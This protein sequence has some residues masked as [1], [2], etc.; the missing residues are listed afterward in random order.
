MWRPCQQDIGEIISRSVLIHGT[1][2][3]MLARSREAIVF[4]VTKHTESLLKNQS[5]DVIF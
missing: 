5:T 3:G 1:N 4:K 2:I